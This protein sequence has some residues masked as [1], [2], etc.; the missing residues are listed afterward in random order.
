MVD[1][2]NILKNVVLTLA[3]YYNEPDFKEWLITANHFCNSLVDRIVTGKPSAQ[4]HQE[5]TSEIGY[6][7][8]FLI[9]SETYSLWAIEAPINIRHRLN[10][11]NTEAGCVLTDN[12]EQYRELKL[13]LLNASHSL[14]AAYGLLHGKIFVK[15][16]LIDPN[17]AYF[18]K[19]TML[20]EIA[21][22]LDIDQNLCNSYA[23]QVYDRF[24]NTSID[25]KLQGITVQYSGKIKARVIQLVKWYLA[26]FDKLPQNMMIGLA[27]YFELCALLQKKDGQIGAYID[28]YWIDYQDINA[29]K[30]LAYFSENEIKEAIQLFLADQDIWGEN[31]NDIEGFTAALQVHL[32]ENHITI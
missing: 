6:F 5:I 30:I 22:V 24:K 15:D 26:K 28:S 25:H 3:D 7:D 17:L 8:P 29:E 27:K 12:I 16:C 13:R 31:L 11:S 32:A 1:N 4:K 2:G 18:L 23:L 9:C 10:F 21:P 14:L 19:Q 20:E